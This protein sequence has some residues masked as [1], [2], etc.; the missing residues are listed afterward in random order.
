MVLPTYPGKVPQTSPK[1]HK[2]RKSFINCW[3]NIRGIFQ[4]YVGGILE[5][6]Q[7]QTPCKQTWQMKVGM[8][9][10]DVLISWIL[11][12][13]LY[14][15][16]N[17]KSHLKLGHQSLQRK[18]DH[19]PRFHPFSGVNS[20]LVSGRVLPLTWVILWQVKNHEATTDVMSKSQQVG[21]RC[22]QYF[23]KMGGMVIGAGGYKKDGCNEGLESSSFSFIHELWYWFGK[24]SWP[25]CRV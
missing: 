11:R 23:W 20:L 24:S 21:C 18:H 10:V 19:I 6:C 16:T 4:G 2:E 13:L 14:P 5:R 12:W 8:Q 15:E 25:I 3:W 9:H 7:E 22:D 1:P 17:K